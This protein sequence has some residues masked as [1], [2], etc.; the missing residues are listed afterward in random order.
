MNSVWD[1][2]GFGIVRRPKKLLKNQPSISM[3]RL[4]DTLGPS[5]STIHRQL[6]SLGKI[7][8]K[9]WYWMHTMCT[10]DTYSGGKLSLLNLKISVIWHLVFFTL[11]Q[12]RHSSHPRHHIISQQSAGK[13]KEGK[14]W[15]LP[16]EKW[17]RFYLP[18]S[19]TALDI[20]HSGWNHILDNFISESKYF[21]LW[22][23]E[24][25]LSLVR[26]CNE[27]HTT[28]TMNE[29]FSW[30][31]TTACQQWK[32]ILHFLVIIRYYYF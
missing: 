13:I 23:F 4:S 25:N 12:Q 16:H 31:Y 14:H 8:S 9:W 24:R 2:H 10:A 15:K 5:K 22:Q 26:R 11:F 1:D 17:K 7:Y 18:L 30:T 28:S 3:H 27:K 19:P 20:L 32:A 6:I 29:Y 21:L